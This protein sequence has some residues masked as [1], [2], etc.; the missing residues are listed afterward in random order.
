[1]P[2]SSEHARSASAPARNSLTES[3][4]CA[5]MS[6]LSQNSQM[7]QGW[8][9]GGG[10]PGHAQ[11]ACQSVMCTAQLVSCGAGWHAAQLHTTGLEARG[12]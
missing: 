7:V 10:Q 12:E 5:Y 8:I 9:C 1:M 2:A 6:G 3:A 11:E 4:C